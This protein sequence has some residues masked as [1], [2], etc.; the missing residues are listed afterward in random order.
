[1]KHLSRTVWLALALAG[2]GGGAAAD[3]EPAD[4]TAGGEHEHA[5]EEHVHQGGE[6]H[7]DHPEMTPELRAFHDVL[8]P[9]YHMD[10]GAERAQ[11][12]CDA[13]DSMASLAADVSEETV[14]AVEGLS[15]SCAGEPDVE[16]TE[17]ALESV[18]DA[19]HHAMEASQ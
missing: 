11:A 5:E 1:M 17:A 18:H 10:P 3:E 2:C 6:E 8:A 19:F 16:G 12:S 4:D 14:T 13:A 15:T 7:R 9:V